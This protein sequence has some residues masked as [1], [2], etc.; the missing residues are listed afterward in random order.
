[1]LFFLV[2]QIIYLGRDM[3]PTQIEKISINKIL[4]QKNSNLNLQK[5]VKVL[6]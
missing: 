5:G 3:S 1:M 6:K 4:R 2:L